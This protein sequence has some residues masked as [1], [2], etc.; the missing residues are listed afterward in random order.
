[1][2][3]KIDENAGPISG[4]FGWFW[5]SNML[6]QGKKPLTI[7]NPMEYIIGYDRL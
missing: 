4:P 5:W 6:L 7:L 3:I 2:K 1:M